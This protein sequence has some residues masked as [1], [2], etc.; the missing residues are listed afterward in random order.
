MKH[1]NEGSL[2]EGGTLPWTHSCFVCG[3]DNP[4]GLRLKSRLED[5]TVY[6]DY[7]P[8]R[9]DLG[10]SNLI[11]GGITMALMDE[12]MTWAAIIRAQAP[13]V[14]AVFNCRLRRP[15][16]VGMPITVEGRVQKSKARLVLT[17]GIVRKKDD[18]SVLATANGKY[19]PMKADDLRAVSK[20][21]VEHPSAIALSRIL[22]H[23]NGDH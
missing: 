3:Q 17:H 20:D 15:V 9:E 7:T 2:P 18:S 12:V 11:H 6:M 21:F 4:R 22:P 19:V 13:C 8:R 5:G 1:S 23:G 14:A 10:Y 16:T